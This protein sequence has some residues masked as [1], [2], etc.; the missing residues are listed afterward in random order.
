MR[1]LNMSVKYEYEVMILREISFYLFD[2]GVKSKGG[3]S[4]TIRLTGWSLRTTTV[5]SM[6]IKDILTD[7]RM[8]L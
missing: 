6:S 4:K 1:S 7:I 2:F 5:F 3:S 8:A